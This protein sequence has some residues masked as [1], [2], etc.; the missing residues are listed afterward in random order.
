MTRQLPRRVSKLS[1][2]RALLHKN[3]LLQTRDRKSPLGGKLGG[4]GA[5]AFQ[6]CV[7]AF[8]FLVMWLP[9]YYIPPVPHLQQLSS[10]SLELDTAWWSGPQPYS[11]PALDPQFQGAAHILLAPDT[12]AVTAL[13]PVLA[14]ALACAPDPSKYACLPGR[15]TN[16]YCLFSNTTSMPEQC[17]TQATCM[18]DET[19]YSH[20]LEPQQGKPPQIGIMP[21]EAAAVDRAMQR[22]AEI[23]AVLV[24]DHAR[25]SEGG[26]GNRGHTPQSSSSAGAGNGKESG[27]MTET[28]WTSSRTG[29]TAAA[30]NDPPLFAHSLLDYRIRINHT[31]IPPTEFLYDMFDVV[32]DPFRNNGLMLYKQHWFFTNL[33]LALERSIIGLRRSE[34]WSPPP[35]SPAPSPSPDPI[36]SP[37]P[38]PAPAPTPSSEP[39]STHQRMLDHED[40]GPGN[41]GSLAGGPINDVTGRSKMAGSASSTYPADVR[42]SFKPFPWPAVTEDLGAVS[43]GVLFNLLLVFAFLAPARAV[44]GSIVRE[45]ELRLREG[46]RIMG[47]GEVGYWGSWFLTHWVSLLVSG[48]LCSLVGTYPFSHTSIA[49]MILFFSLFTASLVFFSYFMSTLFSTSRVAGT[50]AQLLYAISMLPGFLAPALAP[51]GGP[52]LYWAC[53]TPPS[54]ASLFAGCLINWELV[55]QGINWNTLWLPVTPN[56]SWSAGSVLLLLALDVLIYAFLAWYCDKGDIKVALDDV[57]VDFSGGRITALLGHNGA[58]KTTLIHILTGLTSPTYGNAI[59]N[60]F[61]VRSEMGRIRE[62][63]GVCPQHDVLWPDLTVREHLQLYAAIK[64]YRGADVGQV[65]VEAGEQVGLAAKLDSQ[66]GDLSG[67][68]KRKLSVAIAFLGDPAVVLIDEPTS[69]MDPYTRR[70][71]WELIRSYRGRAAVVL[72]THSME[73]ADVLG[74][75]VVI[76]GAGRVAAHGTPM[77]LKA[78]HGEG[79]TLTL[80]LCSPPPPPTPSNSYNQLPAAAATSTPQAQ[81]QQL[82]AALGGAASG[83][84][85]RME[86]LEALVQ[87]HVPGAQLIRCTGGGRTGNDSSAVAAT[88][89]GSGEMVFQLPRFDAPLFPPLLRVLDASVAATNRAAG[90]G[91]LATSAG[92]RAGE[93]AGLGVSSYGL[94]VTTLEEVFLKVTEET[95]DYGVRGEAEAEMS[96]VRGGR[97]Y[98]TDGGAA[99]TRAGENDFAGAHGPGEEEGEEESEGQ[100]LSQRLPHKGT[101]EQ[102]HGAHTSS[103]LPGAVEQQQ[104]EVLAEPVQGLALLQQQLRAQLT[105]RALCAARGRLTLLTQLV[106]PLLLVYLSLWVTSLSVK[107]ADKPA[108][109]LTRQHVLEGQPCVLSAAPDVRGAPDGRLSAWMRAFE[110]VYDS[111]L[112]KLYQGGSVD[113]T[114]DGW[115]LSHWNG[116]PRRPK[117]TELTA[118]QPGA[119]NPELS[120]DSEGASPRQPG[121]SPRALRALRTSDPAD[122]ANVE[123]Y[124]DGPCDPGVPSDPSALHVAHTGLANLAGTGG[125]TAGIDAASAA[126]SGSAAT[127]VA[128]SAGTPSSS[129]EFHSSL[130][131]Q[132]SRGAQSSMEFQSSSGVRSRDHTP[133]PAYDAIHVTA[134]PSL[135]D[136]LHGDSASSTTASS[137]SSPSSSGSISTSSSTTISSSSDPSNSGSISRSSSTASSENGAHTDS[138]GS[139]SMPRAS[140]NNGGATAQLTLLVN[141]TAVWGMPAAISSAST[142]LLR[143][144]EE[145]AHTEPAGTQAVSAGLGARAAVEGHSHPQGPFFKLVAGTPSWLYW[146][147]TLGWDLVQYSLSATGILLLVVWYDLPQYSGPRLPAVV[148]LL[149][150]LGVSSLPLTY[151]MQ[152]SFTDEMKALQRL[153][154]LFFLVGYLGFVAVWIMD[155]ILIFTQARIFVA[156]S[157]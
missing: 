56:S 54:A 147:S 91:S 114:L 102:H 141:Q 76:M 57:D 39:S 145:A 133:L 148:A 135:Q 124:S 142:G 144:L 153:N 11:G 152:R 116:E 61:D 110:P 52:A 140:S 7:P 68:Q 41:L 10:R 90:A 156:I 118:S 98:G 115:L 66:A 55:S 100:H 5:F 59:L 32:P 107:S 18:A 12:P 67:G 71:T 20:L 87:R 146:T 21:D 19:C 85:G 26:V 24:F 155:L 51:Y 130:G 33:Q 106:V 1:Q 82:Q 4:W 23:D 79:Y 38:F 53:L 137:F 62:S 40:A 75:D 113:G 36:P 49:V 45:K 74:D 108:V 88:S 131:V 93:L 30:A 97:D 96:S 16:F 149:A 2:F 3:V 112:T 80:S 99:A 111:G 58:G 6:L 101:S 15:P 92:L 134:L 89:R 72:T 69:G 8:F 50:A 48:I 109:A 34:L 63:L 117:K 31:D 42:V 43:A 86:A 127:T 64:G 150:G 95:T 65:A 121:S 123:A 25:G 60:G 151:L 132:S 28:K 122:A 78:A 73:E 105:K 14:R 84:A 154:T 47:L 119:S 27:R 139:S 35:P 157:S 129:T 46:M 9:K 70:F 120:I 17:K 77:E 136:W 128:N 29:R 81:S 143:Y 13:A 103:A 94:S 44:V 22:P 138:M 125:S 37:S 126:G 83:G 104:E